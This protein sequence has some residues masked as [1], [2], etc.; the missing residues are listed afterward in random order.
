MD[1]HEL[2]EAILRYLD[3]EL[4]G[5]EER[6]LAAAIRDDEQGMQLFSQLMRIYG[7]VPEVLGEAPAVSPSGEALSTKAMRSPRTTT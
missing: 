4:S 1:R 7:A 3:G 6:S 5:D 2:T